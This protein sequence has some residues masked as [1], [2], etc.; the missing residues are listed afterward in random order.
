MAGIALPQGT[1]LGADFLA[2]AVIIRVT[3]I[4]VL[5]QTG[6]LKGPRTLGEYGRRL[7]MT[8]LAGNAIM[9]T[10]QRKSRHAM[11]EFLLRLQ[12]KAPQSSQKNENP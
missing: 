3:G 12:G 10:A 6:P 5:V 7:F 9:F 11:V 1:L 4:A 8:V 2:I